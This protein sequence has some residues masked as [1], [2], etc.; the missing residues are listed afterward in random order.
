[1]IYG[2][3][4]LCWLLQIVGREA[5]VDI[6][7]AIVAADREENRN[8]NRYAIAWAEGRIPLP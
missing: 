5:I 6:D 4:Y 7:A 3:A 8:R 2:D 1:M